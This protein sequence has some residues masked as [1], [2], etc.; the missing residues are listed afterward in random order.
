[1]AR[2]SWREREDDGEDYIRAKNDFNRP[3]L[4]KNVTNSTTYI[5]I[6]YKIHENGN[7]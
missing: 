5:L 2:S 6:Y 3:I 7:S 4:P 1:M